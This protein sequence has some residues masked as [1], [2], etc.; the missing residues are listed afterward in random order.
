MAVMLRRFILDGK[1]R[2]GA[3]RRPK[4]VVNRLRH[5]AHHS[6]LLPAKSVEHILA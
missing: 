4:L 2:D 3:N 5:R 6:P 1:S